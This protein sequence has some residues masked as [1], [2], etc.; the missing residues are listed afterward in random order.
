[1]SISG[2]SLQR[3]A[4][5]GKQ[6]AALVWISRALC[7]GAEKLELQMRFSTLKTHCNAFRK[8]GCDAALCC[9]VDLWYSNS[10]VGGL[11]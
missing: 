8:Q 6:Q 5:G 10:L 3:V 11:A 7:D 4:T 9:Q 1:M 2:T